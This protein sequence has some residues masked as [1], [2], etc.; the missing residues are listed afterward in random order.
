MVFRLVG[1][2]FQMSNTGTY[3]A[4]EESLFYME[5]TNFLTK[6]TVNQ[7][8]K[9]IYLI[10]KGRN[11]NFQS[12]RIPKSVKNIKCF[13]V[14]SKHS[15]Y[16]NIPTPKDSAYDNHACATIEDVIDNVLALG[17]SISLIKSTQHSH[18]KFDNSSFLRMKK[19]PKIRIHKN[20]K[21]QDMVDPY[22][23]FLVIWS[24]D[25]EVNHTCKIKLSTWLKTV[26]FVRDN[27]NNLDD[28]QYTLYALC[29]GNEKNSHFLVNKLYKEELIRLNEV[30]YKY[31]KIHSQYIPIM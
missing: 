20:N 3:A 16:K 31:S 5:L 24:N 17:L 30:M 4:M 18:M 6:L 12:T 8:N 1:N 7:Q 2:T 19:T 21:F 14:K 29:L 13:Y 9:V 27:D 10:K 28:N 11:I 23:L 22:I 25:F 15:I 26:N